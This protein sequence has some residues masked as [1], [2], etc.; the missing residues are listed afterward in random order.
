DGVAALVDAGRVHEPGD[1]VRDGLGED[2]LLVGHGAGVVHH[3]DEVDLVDAPADGEPLSR[4]S[5][6]TGAAA[7]G[8]GHAGRGG[9]A[10]AGAGAGATRA[11]A[12][13]AGAPGGER[14]RG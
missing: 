6:G 10:G 4:A 9:P 7:A 2:L 1:H 5:T 14:E 8:G 13:V 11:A 12:A 3:Q